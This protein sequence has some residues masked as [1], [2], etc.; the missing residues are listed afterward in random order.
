MCVPGDVR[1]RDRVLEGLSGPVSTHTGRYRAGLAL[2]LFKAAAAAEERGD[3]ADW[4]EV[5]EAASR[6]G[7]ELVV[8]GRLV[9]PLLSLQVWEAAWRAHER[10][11]GGTD[12]DGRM[13]LALNA[14]HALATQLVTLTQ[15]PER[16]R[17]AG[18]HARVFPDAA[19]LAVEL[20]DPVAAELVM[21]AARRE[22]VGLL[23]GE[24]VHN[25]EVGQTV[26]EAAEGIVVANTATPEEGSFKDGDGTRAL[27][28]QT[29]SADAIQGSRERA[30]AAATAVIGPAAALADLSR[31]PV[32]VAADLVGETA[33]TGSES[34]VLQL[35]RPPADPT[36]LFW[37]LALPGGELSCGREQ[38]PG[39]LPG[40]EEE[41]FWAR[42]HDLAPALLPEPLRQHLLADRDRPPLR[43]TIV[44]TGLLGVPFDQLPLDDD[45]FLLDRA[46]VVL[47][48]SLAMARALRALPAPPDAQEWVS[49]Y[50][51]LRLAHARAESQALAQSHSPLVEVTGRE[52]LFAALDPDAPARGLLALGLHGSGDE[53]GWAQTKLLP[54]GS[55][56]TAAEALRWAAPRVAVLSSCHSRLETVDGTELS[57]FPAALLLRGSSTVIGSLTKIDDRATAQII[58]LFWT[59]TA[60]G[61]DPAH[62]LAQAKRDWLQNNPTHTPHHWLWAPLIAYGTHTP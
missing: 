46:D 24:L 33:G 53:S 42:A 14:V 12:L 20:G 56:V 16:A 4:G 57:G 22:R 2:W 54:D 62:A 44:P 10:L 37:A 9:A 1:V 30:V 51:H 3:R 36:V 8:G 58:S 15:A 18:E 27:A 23:L 29:H 59:H 11:H 7:E 26:R 17:V 61:H 48:G 39:P 32:P 38:L 13:A 49:A 55:T 47:T 19:A 28:W 40:I 35:Y 60:Q 43:L 50:D 21:E 25:P 5:L 41:G 45:L 31:I 34:A 6:A 52:D